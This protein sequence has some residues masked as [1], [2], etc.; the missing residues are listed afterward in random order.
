VTM[1]TEKSAAIVGTEDEGLSQE[2]TAR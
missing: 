2:S 1:A